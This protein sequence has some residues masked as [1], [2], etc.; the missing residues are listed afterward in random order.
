MDLQHFYNAKLNT[1][2]GARTVQLCHMR[3]KQAL[4]QAVNL[5]LVTRNVADQ[6]TPPRV[7]QQEMQ[8][9]DTA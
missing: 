4:D 8:T 7:T 3:I 5:G 2:C 1:G 6:V 9:W